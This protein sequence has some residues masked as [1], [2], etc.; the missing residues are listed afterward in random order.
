MAST[1]AQWQMRTGPKCRGQQQISD[2][3]QMRTPEHRDKSAGRANTK[4]RYDGFLK[5]HK[6]FLYNDSRCLE[7]SLTMHADNGPDLRSLAARVAAP[8]PPPNRIV[9]W[10]VRFA[11]RSWMRGVGRLW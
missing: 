9:G 11:T 4:T 5:T 3:F 1:V 2:S 10:S 6:T 7:L 8:R